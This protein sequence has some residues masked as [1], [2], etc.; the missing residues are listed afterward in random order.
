MGLERPSRAFIGLDDS[1]Q[2]KQIETS[3]DTMTANR[4]NALADLMSWLDESGFGCDERTAVLVDLD[5]TSIGARGRNDRIIDLARVRAAERTASGALGETL[6]VEAFRRLYARLNR[7]ECHWLTEDNQDYVAYLS[8][9]VA[10]GVF[11]E[12]RF[13]DMMAERQVSDIVAFSDQC[14]SNARAMP[15]QAAGGPPRGA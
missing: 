12:D 2:P 3:A 11:P 4:W 6:D 10:G 5:K 15:R 9:M 14:E 7:T 8:L 1:T 13:W